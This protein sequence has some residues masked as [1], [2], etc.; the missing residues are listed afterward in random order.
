LPHA[1][2][3]GLYTSSQRTK[4]YCGRLTFAAGENLDSR[5]IAYPDNRRSTY[6]RWE[7]GVLLLIR[8]IISLLCMRRRV[9]GQAAVRPHF[10]CWSV[11]HV[12]GGKTA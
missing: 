1:L 12:F 3:S 8:C 4:G 6:R 11:L 10:R 7:R 2:Q 5:D 9:S